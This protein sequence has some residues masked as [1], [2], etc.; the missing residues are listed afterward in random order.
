[1]IGFEGPGGGERKGGRERELTGHE[2][3]RVGVIVDVHLQA[4]GGSRKLIDISRED[5]ILR[6]IA[7]SGAC[8]KTQSQPLPRA[9]VL[10]ALCEKRIRSPLKSSAQGSVDA[11]PGTDHMYGQLRLMSW[12][13]HELPVVVW[14]FLR[15]SRS[16]VCE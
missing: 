8:R 11:P 6:R 5:F 16:V 13:R 10:L 4:G 9:I 14:R 2:Q 12:P 15:Q 1:M 7:L 3:L